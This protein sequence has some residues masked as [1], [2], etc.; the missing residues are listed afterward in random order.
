[1]LYLIVSILNWILV[2]I[3]SESTSE[4]LSYY[5]IYYISAIL[6]IIS[7]IYLAAQRKKKHLSGKVIF[8]LIINI[9][10]VVLY[11]LLLI[12]LYNV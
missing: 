6:P 5:Y 10:Y 7:I 9:C 3:F 1:M 4:I 8:G 11:S 12:G 2:F